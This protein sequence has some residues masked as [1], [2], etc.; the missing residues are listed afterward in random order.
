MS[1]FHNGWIPGLFI[2]YYKAIDEVKKKYNT[3]DVEFICFRTF[4]SLGIR[5]WEFRAGDKRLFV[6][7]YLEEKLGEPRWHILIKEITPELKSLWMEEYNDYY[8][9]LWKKYEK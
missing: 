4:G 2:F 3:D 9:E 5:G 6:T 8:K 7:T 1:E